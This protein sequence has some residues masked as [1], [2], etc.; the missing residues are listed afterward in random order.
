MYPSPRVLVHLC[1]V[2]DWRQAQGGGEHRPDSLSSQGFVHLSAPEQVHLPANRL[3][4]GRTDLVLLHIDPAKLADPVRWEPGVPT[5]PEAMLFP[6][7]YGP[8]PVSAVMTTTAYVPD[9]AGRFAP[10]AG[11]TPSS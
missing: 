11:D 10:L 1:S 9:A 8:L 6:H 5:D 7:L 4:S 3:Y 2:E